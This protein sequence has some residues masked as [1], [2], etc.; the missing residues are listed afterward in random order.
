M[1]TARHDAVLFAGENHMI[2]L[3]APGG[4]D[5]AVSASCWRCAFSEHG[6]GWVLVLRNV[7]AASGLDALPERAV[8]SDN[9][10]LARMVVARF[11]Q[12]FEGFRDQGYA[13]LE[14]APAWFAQRPGGAATHRIACTTEAVTVVLEWGEML[15]GAL[16]VFHNTSGPIPYHVSAVICHCARGAIT[17]NGRRARGEV[18]RVQGETYSSAFLAFSETWAAVRDTP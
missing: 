7:A 18:R 3:F 16:E 1:M 4:E 10:A 6:E 9:T 14:P 8:Y 2:T 12:Y 5:T 17:A 13:A 15:D 11:N